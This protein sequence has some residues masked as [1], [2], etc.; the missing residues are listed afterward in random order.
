MRKHLR[1]AHREIHP[2]RRGRPKK[3]KG[4]QTEVWQSGIP[5]QRLFHARSN[6]AFFEIIRP[7]GTQPLASPAPEGPPD[8]PIFQSVQRRLQAFEKRPPLI[9]PAVPQEANP[10]LRKTGWPEYLAG[11]DLMAVAP[12]VDLPR[13]N[14]PALLV[15]TASLD[16]LIRLARESI[17]TEKINIFD[18]TTINMFNDHS[19]K[20]GQP[21][22]IGLQQTTFDRYQRIWMKLLSFIFRT[23]HP[24]FDPKL[25]ARLKFQL[26]KGQ[27]RSHT[28]CLTSALRLADSPSEGAADPDALSKLRELV[29]LDLL[30][31]SLSVLAQTLQDNRYQ[32]VL[33]SFLAI[34]GIDGFNVNPMGSISGLPLTL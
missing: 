19:T 10:W 14:E 2:Q 34:L 24:D 18:Q 5:C 17:L 30:N 20:A 4:V 23:V 16:R 29:D 8:Q 26:T 13:R 31:F 12:L 21:L 33:V 27:V 15:L 25:R 11:V 22:M 32:S 6:S 28:A 3:G 7:A 9:E 1:T